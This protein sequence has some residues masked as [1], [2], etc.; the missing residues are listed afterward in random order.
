MP[1]SFKQF[2]VDDRECGMKVSTDSVLLGA[3]APLEKASQILDIG[4]G[5][6]LLALMSAQRSNANIVAVEMEPQAV[7]AAKVNIEESPWQQRLHIVQSDI[8]DFAEH[9]LATFDHIICNPPYFLTGPQTQKQTRADARHTNT[10]SFETLISAME[11]LLTKDGCA[12]LIL[13]VEVSDAFFELLDNSRLNLSLVQQVVPATGKLP[14]RVLFTLCATGEKIKYLP[15]LVLR[16]EKN[17]DTDEM[18]ALTADF[19]LNL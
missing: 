16:D 15:P 5:S 6:G 10:L 9:H 1:F 17:Q 3:W 2:H 12:S 13:P 14:R 4:T 8:S 11:K 18:T 7:A 19:Y